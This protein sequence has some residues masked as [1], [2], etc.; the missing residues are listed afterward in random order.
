V[1]TPLTPTGK[2]QPPI[3]AA[4]E[5]A[6]GL[7]SP[8]PGQKQLSE[9]ASPRPAETARTLSTLRASR[10]KR[11]QRAGRRSQQPLQASQRRS[12]HYRIVP[13]VV[14]VRSVGDKGSAG[15][16]GLAAVPVPALPGSRR[17]SV[18]F[19]MEANDTREIAALEGEAALP[20]AAEEGR[21]TGRRGAMSTIGRIALLCMLQPGWPSAWQWAV[22]FRESQLCTHSGFCC[23]QGRASSRGAPIALLVNLR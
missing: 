17:V 9:L 15:P 10:M 2:T 20:G 19:D 21:G 12:S 5:V 22:C 23:V 8:A 7:P 14:Q 11:T 3:A 18:M 1:P 4:S 6:A 16:A 13:A